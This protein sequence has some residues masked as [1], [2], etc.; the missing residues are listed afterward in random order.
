MKKLWHVLGLVLF[1]V[2]MT[3]SVAAV[4]PS[5]EMLGRFHEVDGRLRQAM[6]IYERGARTEPRNHRIRLRLVHLWLNMGQPTRAIKYYEEVVM[7][8]P[9]EA[10]HHRAL[11]EL[12][13]S[14]NDLPS[15]MRRYEVLVKLVPRDRKVLR[16]L[17]SFY[18]WYQQDEKLVETLKQLVALTPRDL[19]LQE[20]LIE[21]CSTGGTT[22]RPFGC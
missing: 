22:P 12:Y 3:A 16:T 9:S 18:R 14:V 2:V 20:E 5:E 6:D 11:A 10:R 13:R 19:E 7:L 17:A 21:L 8:L 15:M 4:F 1:F